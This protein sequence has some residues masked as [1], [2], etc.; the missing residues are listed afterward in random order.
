[1]KDNLMLKLAN[2]KRFC[3]KNVVASMIII[4]I[5]IALIILMVRY[6]RQIMSCLVWVV[7]I[8][9]MLLS[10]KTSKT[11][12]VTVQDTKKMVENA[13]FKVLSEKYRLLEVDRPTCINEIEPTRYSIVQH[14]GGEVFYRFIIAR[15]GNVDESDLYS[16]QQLLQEIIS[17]RLQSNSFENI[18][19]K[20]YCGIP[21]LYVMEVQVDIYN[22]NYYAI[23]IMVIDSKRKAMLI[24]GMTKQ[25]HNEME[26][27]YISMPKD[28]EF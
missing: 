6:R 14:L 19:C 3:K 13:L 28:D 25:R 20:S 26:K 22:P 7:I 12:K 23:D 27:T 18:N 16:K 17:Q 24:K 5:I 4:A 15:K 9:V 21:Y 8:A 1:M 11:N 10:G 2:I